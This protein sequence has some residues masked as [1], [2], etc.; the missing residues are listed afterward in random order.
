VCEW[1]ADA[2]AEHDFV[3]EDEPYRQA[4]ARHRPKPGGGSET[5]GHGSIQ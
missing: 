4:P 3:A 2:L 5:R 1:V